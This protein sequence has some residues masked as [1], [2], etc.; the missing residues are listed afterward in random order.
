MKIPAQYCS[1]ELII[2]KSRFLTELF[3]VESQE[4]GRHL[5]KL[6]KEKYA[7]ASHVVHAFVI[8]K[9]CGIL[10]CSDDGEPPGTAGRP[11]LEVLKNSGITNLMV[12]VTRWF[13][14]TLLGTGG[15]VKAYSES[16]KAVLEKCITKE[17]VEEICFTLHCSYKDFESIKR[18]LEEFKVKQNECLFTENVCLKG[19]FPAKE[20]EPLEHFIKEATNGGA[21]IIF[22]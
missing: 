5:L 8:G 13:G 16:A 7:G 19:C 4:E 22:L 2:K 12:T 1:T 17:L 3:A 18:R 14:G 10:G 21:E 9:T 6:Q 11:V 15:L 20:K